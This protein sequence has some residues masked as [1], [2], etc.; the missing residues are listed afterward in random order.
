MNYVPQRNKLNI[1]LAQ[2]AFRR[3]ADN[4]WTATANTAEKKYD[5]VRPEQIERSHQ[6][7]PKLEENGKIGKRAIIVRFGIE[8][9]LDVVQ[10]ASFMLKRNNHAKVFVTDDLTST[11][12]IY[13]F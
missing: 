3:D 2:F 11:G 13:P 10:R 8:S 6:L 4:W 9:T 5:Q 12:A 1:A 7:G